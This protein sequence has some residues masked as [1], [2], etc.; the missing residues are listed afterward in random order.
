MHPITRKIFVA[1]RVVHL[2]CSMFCLGA[3]VL[4][5]ATGFM[6]N[7][8]EMFSS[9]EVEPGIVEKTLPA[10]ILAGA[11]QEK[12][13]SHL[14]A[15]CGVT[16]LLDDFTAEEEMIELTFKRPGGRTDVT[17]DRPDGKMKIA[18]EHATIVAMLLDL[19]K[20]S[21]AGDVWG[22]LIDATAVCLL[23][24]CITGVVLWLATPKRRALG[25]IALVIGLLAWCGAYFFCV[26]K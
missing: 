26:P 20:G 12:I 10:D 3:I 21:A 18:T 2:V 19:H 4:F 15:Q 5:A 9:E 1:T 17:I 24:A 22:I 25:L 16:G 14:R 8:E 11:E 7:N 6:L 23:L 13:V